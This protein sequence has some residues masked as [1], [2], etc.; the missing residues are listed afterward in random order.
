M[1]SCSLSL[2]WFYIVFKSAREFLCAGAVVLLLSQ[3]M[4]LENIS[5]GRLY[6]VFI[7][8]EEAIWLGISKLA[9]GYWRDT[10]NKTPLTGWLY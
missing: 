10:V 5:Y 7:F 1:C 4:K 3:V 2:C 6:R 9:L 8:P